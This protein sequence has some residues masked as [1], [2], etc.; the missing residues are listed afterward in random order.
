MSHLGLLSLLEQQTA[1]RTS[2]L[3]AF[4]WLVSVVPKFAQKQ[5][6]F[7]YKDI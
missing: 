4:G 2:R 3:Q 1:I 6:K 5:Q 7:N